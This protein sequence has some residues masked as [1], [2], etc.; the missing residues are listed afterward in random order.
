MISYLCEMYREGNR[1]P[2]ES[3]LACLGVKVPS[4]PIPRRE[5]NS[6]DLAILECGEDGQETP[7]I[8]IEVKVDD[9][10]TGS[11]QEHYQTVRY[12]SRWPSCQA[13]LFITLGKGEY[14][15]PPRSDR[16][17]WVRIRQFQKAIE[18]IKTK[19]RIISDWLDEVRREIVLQDNVLIA[20]KSRAAEYR[21]GT[22][23]IYLFGQLT[24]TLKP[25]FAAN[26]IDVEMTCYTYGSGP[27]TIFNFGWAREPLYMEIN[28]SGRLNLKM[29]LDTAESE[30]SRRER[31]KQEIDKCQQLPFAIS[32]TFH[33]GGKIGGSKTIASFDVGLINKDGYLE[34]QPSIED[35]KQ[36]IFSVVSTFYGNKATI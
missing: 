4:N 18:A 35:T 11:S 13:Y 36:S 1:E 3:F 32:A 26:N 31:V 7:A 25:L 17:A 21:G 30:N 19:D 9:S 27:D 22:W 15:H 34:C 23:N 6:V 14:Y 2:L 24:E 12:A 5:W 10:E 33:P 16:F 28:Y 8:L 20:D 29:S